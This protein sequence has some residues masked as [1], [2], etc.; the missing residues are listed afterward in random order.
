L[1]ESLR[2]F[3]VFQQ[4]ADQLQLELERTKKDL[5]LTKEELESNKVFGDKADVVS[6]T[7]IM[8]IEPTSSVL[9]PAA[10]VATDPRS[11]NGRPPRAE[12]TLTKSHRRER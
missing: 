12:V 7:D 5:S 8:T 1:T 3:R 9:M 10:P 6:E 2:A 4:R 11:Q